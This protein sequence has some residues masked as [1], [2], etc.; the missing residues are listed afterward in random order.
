MY[1]V[2]ANVPTSVAG[3]SVNALA[4]IKTQAFYA[5]FHFFFVRFTVIPCTVGTPRSP[6][7]GQGS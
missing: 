6:I 4:F 2:E 7:I 1:D 3:G 5:N